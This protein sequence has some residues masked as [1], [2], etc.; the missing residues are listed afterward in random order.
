MVKTKKVTHI[1]VGKR[2]GKMKVVSKTVYRKPITNINRSLQPFAQRYIAR[3][4]Y[5]TV[6]QL[7]LSN[8]Y[9]YQFN[10]N[11]LYDPD[12]TGTGHQPYG[13]DQ[14]AGIYNRYRVIS[15]S[16]QITAYSAGAFNGPLRIVTIPTNE[17]TAGW[18]NVS[19]VIENPRAKWI[20]QVPGGEQKVL[21]GKV[22][23]PSLMGRTR[24]QY[25]ADDRFQA[26]VSVSPSELAILN[27]GG[28]TMLDSSTDILLSVSL[29]F[30][31]E[32][33]DIKNQAQ[34]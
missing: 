5:A 21:K 31:V 7:N 33:F 17:A 12:R 16:Y 32:F 29:Q 10:I 2:G 22:Y 24:Q 23:I 8:N 9:L 14:L 28:G 18:N 26:Q 11:S 15:C 1:K 27:I 30:K 6:A 34:S 4:K 25:M 20:T 19:E 13:F 3:M